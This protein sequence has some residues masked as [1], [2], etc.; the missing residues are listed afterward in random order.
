LDFQNVI[1]EAEIIGELAD[2]IAETELPA[3][4]AWM[5]EGVVMLQ[6][7]GAI[8]ETEQHARLIAKWRAA[9]N[10]A[11]AFILDES[12]CELDPSAETPGDELYDDYKK[13]ALANGVRPFGRT[14]FYEALDEGAGRFSV[15]RADR[16]TGVEIIGVRRI[17]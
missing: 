8:P 7:K 1:P 14:G 15:Y 10:S 9:N 4:L 11:L 12:A 2:R 3:V 6:T 16:R 13:W 17:C 5:L